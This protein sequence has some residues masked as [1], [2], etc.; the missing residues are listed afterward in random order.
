MAKILDGK[1]LASKIK[2]DLKTRIE[3]EK[4]SCCLA[5]ILVGGNPASRIYVNGKK[6]D[7]A[8]IGIKSREF[9]LP[10]KTTESELL[11]LV[12]ALNADDNV[13]GILVQLPL[14]A[15]IDQEAIINAISPSKD[16]DAFHPINVGKIMTGNY[17]FLPCTPAGIIELLIENDVQIAGKEC[18]VVGRSNIVGKP[19][20]MLL[21][22]QNATVTIAHSHTRNLAEVCRRADIL[23]AAVGKAELI[24][25][26][27]VKKGAVIIDVGVNRL[28]NGQLVGDVAYPEVSKIASAI[29]P[30]PGGVGPMTRAILM[31]NTLQASTYNRK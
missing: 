2:T 26:D 10:S 21:L 18:V 28:P 9:E 8:E 12:E 16:V 11:A 17:T 25:A 19:A 5:V 30:V 7:C 4:I 29:S 23:I 1:L 6:N 13:D 20:A 15:H 22:Q 14:P 31:K 24:T 3:K 27:M